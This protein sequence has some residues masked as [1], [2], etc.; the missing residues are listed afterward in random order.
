MQF[1][2]KNIVFPFQFN[3]MRMNCQTKPPRLDKTSDSI[4]TSDCTQAL[5][6]VDGY[7]KSRPHF[8]ASSV[9]NREYGTVC[10]RTDPAG[11]IFVFTASAIFRNLISVFQLAY[12]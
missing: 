6:S 5:E 10:L 3:E 7:R 4:R 9:R 8:S 11:A 2:F 1:D 12:T